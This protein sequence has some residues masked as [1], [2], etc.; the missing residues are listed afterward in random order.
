[1]FIGQSDNYGSCTQA[2]GQ[3]AEKGFGRTGPALELLLAAQAKEVAVAW[4]DDAA[5]QL[6]FCAAS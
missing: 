5:S 3:R 1:V 4:L 6:R 2:G